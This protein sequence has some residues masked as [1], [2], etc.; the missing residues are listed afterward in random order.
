MDG[1]FKI[2]FGFGTRLVCLGL[3]RYGVED[4]G[5]PVGVAA[6]NPFATVGDAA[7]RVELFLLLGGDPSS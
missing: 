1:D 4:V 6:E 7:G 5:N 3:V 2:F